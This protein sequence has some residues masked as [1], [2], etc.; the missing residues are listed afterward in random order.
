MPG[1][2]KRIADHFRIGFGLD[3]KHAIERCDR[4]NLTAGH[5]SIV[6]AHFARVCLQ[7][8]YAV[9]YPEGW[10]RLASS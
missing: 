6:G 8:C 1:A 2:V 3:D 10:R 9:E 7:I 4:V 5:P